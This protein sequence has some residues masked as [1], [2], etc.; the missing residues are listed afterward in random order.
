MGRKEGGV[1]G[2]GNVA[3]EEDSWRVGRG[4]GR[5]AE[6]TGFIGEKLR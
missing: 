1:Y 2:R 5:M 4:A 6:E 3:Y